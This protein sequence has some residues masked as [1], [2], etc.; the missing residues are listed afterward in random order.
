ML[1]FIN[2]TITKVFG[3]KSTR[4]IREIMPLVEKTKAEFAKLASLSN[5]QLRA[6][7]D[8]FKQRIRNYLADIDNEIAAYRKQ[9][10]DHPDM[11]PDDKEKIYKE[12]D[13]LG[14]ERDKKLEEVLLELLPE[15]FAVVKETARRF[16]EN[17]TLEATATRLD[18]DLS[19]KFPNI[20]IQGEKVIYQNQWMAAGNMITWDMVHYD[21]QLIGGVVLHQGKIAEMATGEG[22]TLV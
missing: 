5:D 4:D 9:V 20:Q 7:T 13:A 2:K 19:V 11:D 8:E 1:D 17:K 10:D 16:F 14:K 3:S 15:A 22:K 6:K 18:R 12:I 21:V